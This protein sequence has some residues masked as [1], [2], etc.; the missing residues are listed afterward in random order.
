MSSR[1]PLSSADVQ[2]KTVLV[3]VDLNVPMQA[4]KITDDLRIRR[5]IP[6]I[7]HLAERGARVVLLSHYGRPKGQYEPTLSLSPLVD[8]LQSYLPGITVHFG[9][10]CLGLAAREAVENTPFG[11]VILLEN[12]RFHWQ[13]E[14][15]DAAF[16]QNLAML[17]DLYVNE[18]FSGSHRAHASICGIARYL[19]AFAGL[20]FE[21]EI[22]TLE[23]FLSNPE[24]PLMAIVGGSKVS[25]KLALLEN[26]VEK[27]DMLFI[28]GAMANTFLHVQGKDMGASLLERDMK[29]I[30]RGIMASAEESNC[31]ILLPEDVVV[32]TAL[33]SRSPCTVVS[34]DVIPA[35]SMA[36]DVGPRT[37]DSLAA[38]IARCKMLVWNGPIGA[39]ETSP[40][41][42]STVHLARLV[43]RYTKEG[44]L[45][46][47]AG[48]GD[49]V[50]ALAHAGLADEFTYLSTAGGAFLEWL[51]GKDLPGIAALHQDERKALRA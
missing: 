24:R 19:P 3:R 1:V 41:D 45:Q 9:V 20:A 17:G 8:H 30:V 36:L 47:I 40:F 37:L 44:S 35:S 25:T 23:R 10:D 28:G 7:R 46:S 6:T 48:G 11:S 15:G 26:L 5:V 39:F 31:R 43:A 50:S 51:E 22:S 27:V 29:E 33:S 32:A 2:N 21:E 13:E 4:G 12:L 14:T 18:A 38:E 34:V 16:A 49:T 42:V